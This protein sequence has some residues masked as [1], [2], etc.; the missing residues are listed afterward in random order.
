MILAIVLALIGLGFVLAEV[1]FPSLGMFGLI[2][3]AFIIFGSVLAFDS[4]PVFGWVFVGA[5]IVLVP[6]VVHLGFKL[7]PKLPFGR[8]MIL[9]GPVT[10]PGAGLPDYDYLLEKQGVAATDLRPAG[11][12]RFGEERVSVVSL[13]GMVDQNT[14]I[15]V[16]AV[17]GTEVRVRPLTDDDADE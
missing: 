2:A 9:D 3:G 6:Y 16:V 12:G 13:G 11:T 17:D 1:F 10:E 4:G 5:E 7:L 14:P 8:R 15:V